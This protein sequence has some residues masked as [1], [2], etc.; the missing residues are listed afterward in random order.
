MACSFCSSV[1]DAG[2]NLSFQSLE[3]SFRRFSRSMNKYSPSTLSLAH[4]VLRKNFK[5]ELTLGSW[6]KHRIGIL[7][8]SSAHPK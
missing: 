8:P 3:P 1:S 6:V 2:I 5:L 7:C 4:G